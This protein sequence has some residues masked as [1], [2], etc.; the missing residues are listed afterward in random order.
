MFWPIPGLNMNNTNSDTPNG[1]T[2]FKKTTFYRYIRNT[3]FMIGIIM[4]SA[5]LFISIF[6]P[7]ISPY[8]P[9]KQM[10][11]DRLQSPNAKYIMGT[12]EFGRDIMSRVFAGGTNSLRISIIS[13]LIASTI[14]TLLGVVS[15]YLEGPA[16]YVIMRFM[17]LLFAFPTILLALAISAALG[18]GFLNTVVA[19]SIVYIPVFTRVSRGSVLHIK[20]L[21]YVTAATSIGATHWRKIWRHILPNALGPSIIQVSMAFSW[22]ILT[23]SALSYL[24]LGTQ[25]PLPSWGS[26]ISSSRRMMEIAPWLAIFPG[27]AIMLNVLSFNF[28]GDGL[29]DILD[30]RTLTTEK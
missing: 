27:L 15:A 30:P 17:D 20:E 19:I 13:V 16:D 21:E 3:N 25:P 1:I 10:P 12:D 23:E 29:R 6:A 14:G 7:L 5:L 22:A 2:Q 26:M 24:G 8:S 28:L 4:V 9:I 18:P 11:A